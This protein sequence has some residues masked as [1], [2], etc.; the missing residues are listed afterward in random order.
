MAGYPPED[1][2]D[3]IPDWYNE[4]RN[5]SNTSITPESSLQPSK[6]KRKV[7]RECK[8]C[9]IKLR[10]AAWEKEFFCDVCRTMYDAVMKQPGLIAAQ[11]E[12]DKENLRMKRMRRKD[13]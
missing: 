3:R 8:Q 10:R 12:Y 2:F 5:W 11:N 9:N 1:D 7:F 13:E 6:K 4:Q